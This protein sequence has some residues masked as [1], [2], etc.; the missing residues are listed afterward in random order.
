MM[1]LKEFTTFKQ[2]LRDFL[3]Q[4]NQFADQNNADLYADEV[5]A[6]VRRMVFLCMEGS[7]WIEGEHLAQPSLELTQQE[8]HAQLPCLLAEGGGAEED[9][10]HPRHGE[11]AQAGRTHHRCLVKST[12]LPVTPIMHEDIRR[13]GWQQGLCQGNA[14]GKEGVLNGQLGKEIPRSVITPAAVQLVVT[15]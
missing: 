8:T 9:G 1:E 13:W 11:P 2:H 14:W 7:G 6:A 5:A 15:Q 4:A 10:R 3:V 12:A